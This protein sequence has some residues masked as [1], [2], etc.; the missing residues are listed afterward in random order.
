MQLQVRCEGVDFP[1]AC[2]VFAAPRGVYLY[3]HVVT[4]VALAVVRKGVGCC[5]EVTVD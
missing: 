1:W 3:V 5:C 4:V 2:R